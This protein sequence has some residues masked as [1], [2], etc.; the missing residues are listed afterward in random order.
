MAIGRRSST[1]SFFF[2]NDTAT[3]EIYTLSLHDALPIWIVHVHARDARPLAL[4]AGQRG[5]AAGRI[6]RAAKRHV[7][8]LRTSVALAGDGGEDDAGIDLFQRGVAQAR[9]IE[10]A[11][12]EVLDHDVAVRRELADHPLAFGVLEVER[13]PALVAVGEAER[14]RAVPPDVVGVRLADDAGGIE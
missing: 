8:A 1:L 5:N 4:V 11:A 6:E 3:T 7:H 12:T 10:H 2:F 13:Q 14:R 9:A